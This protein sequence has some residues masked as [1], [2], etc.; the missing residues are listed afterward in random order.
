[1]TMGIDFDSFY[2]LL[3]VSWHCSDKNRHDTEMTRNKET[4]Y[5]LQNDLD[6]LKSQENLQKQTSRRELD[7]LKEQ[8]STYYCEVLVSRQK[9]KRSCTLWLWV[10]ILTLSIIYW[11]YLGTV[12]TFWYLLFF[13][14]I[15]HLYI[16]S[17]DVQITTHKTKDRTAWTKKKLGKNSGALQKSVQFLLHMWHPSC[18]SWY[19][20]LHT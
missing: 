8:T 12:Q 3:I 17:T 6:H 10:S 15:C 4:T 19:I 2:N 9:N 5:R 18:Y 7:S 11:L 13:I 14:L 1:M 16:N 20:L